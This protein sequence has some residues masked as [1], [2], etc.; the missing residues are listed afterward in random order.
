MKG[1]YKHGKRHTRIYDIW[2]SM[3]QRCYN[4]KSISYKNYGKKGV[5]VCDEWRSQFVPFYEWSIK[6]GYND[7]MTLDRIDANG[8]YEPSNCRWVSYTEQA[9]N[10]SNSR[11][12]EWRSEIHTMAEWGRITGIGDSTIFARLKSGWSVERALSTQP[13]R[14][15]NQFSKRCTDEK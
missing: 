14:G 1:N 9:N 2:R 10:K 13:V 15:R 5:G 8:N 4:P 6:N 3:K 12:L 11:L 7:K